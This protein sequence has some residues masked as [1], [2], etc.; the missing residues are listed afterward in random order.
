MSELALKEEEDTAKALVVI[1]K[2]LSYSKSVEAP[3]L[4]VKATVSLLQRQSHIQSLFRHQS[5][6]QSAPQWAC[7]NGNVKY[8]RLHHLGNH[9][10]ESATIGISYYDQG[11]SEPAT[12]GF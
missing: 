10:S 2:M 3:L 12:K 11:H 9:Q 1:Y 5:L 4:A 8:H 6:R 7:Y